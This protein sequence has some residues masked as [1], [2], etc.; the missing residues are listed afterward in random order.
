MR[1]RLGCLT[2][3]GITAAVMT[4]VLLLAAG[5]LGGGALFSPGRLNAQADQ[6]PLGGVRSHA[7]AKQCRACHAAP[8]SADTMSDRCLACHQVIR[9]ELTDPESLHAALGVVPDA[10]P[11]YDCHTEHR[12]EAGALT[13]VDLDDFA[14]DKVG[15]SLDGHA[16][17]SDGSAFACAD[18]H[19]AG[20]ANLDPGVCAD[21]HQRLDAV[22]MAAHADAFGPECLA[23]HDGLDT[24]GDAFDHSLVFPLEGAHT[25]VPCA[26]CHPAARTPADLQAAPDTCFACHQADD[27]HEGEL[28]QDCGACHVPDSWAEVD[29]DHAQTDFPLTG[30]HAGLACGE[31]HRDAT[32]AGTPIECSGCHAD[33]LFHAGLFPIGCADCHIAAGWVPARFDRP[34]TF[35]IAHGESGPSPCR[36]CHPDTLSAYTC[37][38]CHEHDPAEIAEEHRDEGINDFEDCVRCHPTGEKDEAEREGGED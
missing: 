4:L 5:L 19:T 9:D 26:D 14:H 35:P 33:P 11:C 3:G 32:F 23:C 38:G 8:W 37:Y 6:A 21:C 1:K 10:T 15:F 18:C 34:H 29:F 24:Y 17:M 13:E 25:T 20:L 28:G 12:G 30:R 7:E 22:Y 27:A 36:T 2:R 31:C 16:E